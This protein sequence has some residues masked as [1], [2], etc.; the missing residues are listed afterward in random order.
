MF[1]NLDDRMKQDDEAETTRTQR[2]LKWLVVCAV[3]VVV[4][5]ALYLGVSLLE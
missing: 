1:E 4:F 5:G 3:S 2:W